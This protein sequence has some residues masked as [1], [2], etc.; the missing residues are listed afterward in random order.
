MIGNRFRNIRRP[1][2]SRQLLRLK[3]RPVSMMC[4]PHGA[5]QSGKC[6]IPSKEFVLDNIFPRTAAVMPQGNL[7]S[8]QNIRWNRVIPTHAALQK[9]NISSR[10]HLPKSSRSANK[11]RALNLSGRT[12]KIRHKRRHNGIERSSW[13]KGDRQAHTL[14][15]GFVCEGSP[16]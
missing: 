8:Y 1:N 10:R 11:A 3:P 5:A 6:F 14:T 2:R 7:G 15:M 13:A 12:R 4:T 16:A 9:C